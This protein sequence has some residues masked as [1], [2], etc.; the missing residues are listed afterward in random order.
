MRNIFKKHAETVQQ[1]LVPDL[2]LILENSLK[3]PMH[4]RN[5]FEKNIIWKIMKNVLQR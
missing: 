3:Q 2:F 5:S 1:K 4:S